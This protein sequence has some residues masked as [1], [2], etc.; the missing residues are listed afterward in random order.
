MTPVRYEEDGEGGYTIH[1]DYIPDVVMKELRNAPKYTMPPALL[2]HLTMINESA[3]TGEIITLDYNAR[4]TTKEVTTKSGEKK[5]RKY[6]KAVYSSLIGSSL[7]DVAVF[8]M[9]VTNAGN[10]TFNTLDLG[11]IADKYQRIMADKS[12]G[13]RAERITQLW[14]S[15]QEDMT[16]VRENFS[17][18]LVLSLIHI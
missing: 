16:V 17:T 11:R 5:K 9:R 1:G 7:R 8:S 12:E 13:G 3:K 14:G 18:D 4:L 2:K 15:G 10:L 6:Q